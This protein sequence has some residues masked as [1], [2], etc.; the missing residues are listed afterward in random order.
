[1]AATI[2]EAG[3]A[4]NDLQ[5][6]VKPFAETLKCAA[7]GASSSGKTLLIGD[8]IETYGAENVGVISC[9]HGLHTIKSL[10]DERYVKVAED[11]AG[12]RL[13]WAWAKDN[14]SG[15]N[16][17]VC[18]DG[19]TRVLQWIQGD[20]FGTAQRAYEEVL[21]GKPKSKLDAEL[22]AYAI[23][24]SG[25]EE[26]NTQGLWGRVGSEAERLF[27]SFVKLPSNMYWT[28]WEQLTSIDQYKKGVPWKPDTPGN[29]SFGAINGT[30]DFIFRMLPV[31]DKRSTAV[32]RNPPGNNESFTK[33]RDDWRSA[34]I[35]ARIPEF[36]L[37]DLVNI[38][39]DANGTTKTKGATKQ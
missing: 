23:Y 32:F 26:I 13:A 36:K 30:F 19:G 20:V 34:K 4:A 10:I 7:Y 28:F 5:S 6:Q 11:R 35:P 27:N 14:F 12:L 16:Q 8:L 31:T 22:R 25:N 9:E 37:T 21:G 29:L 33:T 39:N 3:V 2:Q 38:I 15:P 1:M 17:W 18:V 24:I